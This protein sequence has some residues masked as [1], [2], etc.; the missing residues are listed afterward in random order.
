M[1]AHDITSTNRAVRLLIE[2]THN[3]RHRFLLMAYDRHRNLEM[4][5][6]YEELFAPDMM[7]KEPV[8]HLNAHGSRLTLKGAEAVKRLYRMWAATNQAVFY[9]ESEQLAVA[10]NFIASVAVGFQQVSGG[11]LF[12]DKVLSYLPATVSRYV[13]MGA[14]AAKTDFKPAGRHM[15]LYKNTFH[16]IWAYDD[17]GRLLG[18][19]VYEPDPNKAVVTRLK[20]ADVVTTQQSARLLGPLIKPLPSFEEMVFGRNQ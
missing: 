19:D 17:R 4:A 9:V 7:V 14:L 6:R 16:M 11:A 8:Y 2:S 5:G 10:D 13:A 20:P 18:E 3:A 1:I 12:F 15:Y